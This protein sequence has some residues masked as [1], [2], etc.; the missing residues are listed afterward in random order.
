MSKDAIVKKWIGLAEAHVRSV[1]S[2]EFETT[3]EGDDFGF[4]VETQGPLVRR[5]N[6]ALQ[7][8]LRD[9]LRKRNLPLHRANDGSI[10][11]QG[12]L[13]SQQLSV[14]LRRG[15]AEALENWSPL[16]RELLRLSEPMVS[17]S[18]TH[19]SKHDADLLVDLSI[20]AGDSLFPD[21]AGSLVSYNLAYGWLVYLAGDEPVSAAD[22]ERLGFAPTFH[23]LLQL[24]RNIGYVWL[25]LDAEAA[26][27]DGLPTFDW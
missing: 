21:P 1:L 18:T 25:K 6:D 17:L 5:A 22:L 12:P 3:G 9:E 26:P 23:E 19:V 10:R 4:V 24:L 8:W 15:L 16:T 2:A 27:I 14:H 11:R 13:K 20:D 7:N